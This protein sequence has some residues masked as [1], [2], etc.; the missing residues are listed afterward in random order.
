M[1]LVLFSSFTIIVRLLYLCP[2][3]LLVNVLSWA[4]W[5]KNPRPW[6]TVYVFAAK[7]DIEI[8][9]LF[10]PLFARGHLPTLADVSPGLLH[11][12]PDTILSMSKRTWTFPSTKPA[13][14]PY[15]FSLP[16]VA[17]VASTK[18]ITIMM[19]SATSLVLQD[20]I[21]L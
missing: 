14:G 9:G 16:V 19:P 21:V 1:L 10:V 8:D 17:V 6:A 2:S 5:C 11:A 12:F 13:I 3:L 15:I 7:K 20:G 4:T 18:S